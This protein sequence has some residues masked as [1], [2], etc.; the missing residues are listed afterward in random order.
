[1]FHAVRTASDTSTLTIRDIT[2]DARKLPDFADHEEILYGE[3]PERGLR[4]IIAI[5]STVLGPALGGTR[6]WPYETFEAGLTDALRLSHGMTQKASVTGLKLG[7][8]KAVIFADSKT[9]KTP[10]MLEAY[11]E[12]LSTVQD[13]Y[14]TAEDVGLCVADADFLRART[15]NISGTSSGG[16]GNPSPF[17]ALGVFLGLKAAVKHRLGKAGVE[18]L[19]VAVQGLGSVGWSLCEQLHDEGAE[20]VV[21]DIDAAQVEKA[22]STFGAESVPSDKIHAADADVF[23]PCA[24]G[25][26]LSEKTIPHIKAKVIA[27]AANNQL[28][29][30]ED[31][32]R[33][34]ERGILYAPD[35]VLNAGGLINVHAER[36]P[37]GYDKA[38]VIGMI[39]AIPNAL[40]SI[41]AKSD[42]T[43]R[44]TAEV[45]AEIADERIAGARR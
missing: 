30:D 40:E 3:D 28:A 5:H 16:S 10:D 35:Y 31:G 2:D 37:G 21:A 39:D 25:G 22:V 6:V 27:G 19:R 14:I 45:A 18:G 12:M 9:E 23:A 20:L 8:G 42:A 33:L 17:T 36:E 44:P 43:G 15:P 26:I 1:M 38:R 34:R 11:A 29:V 41:F 7:G 24:L 4:T 13:R 32:A